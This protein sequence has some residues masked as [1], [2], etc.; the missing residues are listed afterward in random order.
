MVRGHV[1]E[2]SGKTAAAEPSSDRLVPRRS[3]PKTKTRNRMTPTRSVPR[4]SP[5]QTARD[6]SRPTR[7]PLS[8]RNPMRRYRR[9]RNP[10]PVW[11]DHGLL[12]RHMLLVVDFSEAAPHSD[13]DCNCNSTAIVP[14]TPTQ[15]DIAA[16]P[17]VFSADLGV[18]CVRFNTPKSGDRRVRLLQ[19]RPHHRAG[20]PGTDDRGRRRKR[21]RDRSAA[22]ACGI[23]YRLGRAAEIGNRC[24]TRVGTRIGGAE[25]RTA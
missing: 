4:L 20:H 25:L 5:R 17:G 21:G 1:I 3:R 8:S 12:P 24:W 6:T 22:Y 19:S 14:R 2:R 7:R 15:E 9:S 10:Y 18:G 23:G 16:A 11:L 13:K